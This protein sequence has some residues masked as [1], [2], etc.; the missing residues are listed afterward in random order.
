L[1]EP[2]RLRDAEQTVDRWRGW[3]GE[4]PAQGDRIK[5]LMA[6]LTERTRQDLLHGLGREYPIVSEEEPYGISLR[7]QRAAYERAEK[8]GKLSHVAIILEELAE[9]IHAATPE[10]MDTELVQ[11]AASCLKALEVHRYQQAHK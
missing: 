10:E 6:V 5:A 7:A 1:D 4:G 3:I 11:L 2:I 8:A 9:V